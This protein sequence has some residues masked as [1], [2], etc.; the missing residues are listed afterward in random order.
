[1]VPMMLTFAEIRR[2]VPYCAEEVRRQ[3]DTYAHVAH[4]V[5]AWLDALEHKSHGDDLSL[6]MVERWGMLVDP[7]DN[8]TGFR[9][10]DV[11]IGDRMGTRVPD[12]ANALE[13]WMG[14][15][16]D[17]TPLEAYKKFEIIHPFMDGNGRTGKIILNY[18]WGTLLDPIFPPKNLFGYAIE[19]P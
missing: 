12:L 4:M 5:N 11:F 1:M 3:H 19:N 7:D 14:F 2:I 8:P 6:G 9:G 18:L 16:P 13:R 10:A 17:M 15:L